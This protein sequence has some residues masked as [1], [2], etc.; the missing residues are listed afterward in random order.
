MTV[1]ALRKSVLKI[2]YQTKDLTLDSFKSL[3]ENFVCHESKLL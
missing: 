2:A 3:K 1:I